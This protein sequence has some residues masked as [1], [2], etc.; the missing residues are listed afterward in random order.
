MNEEL[1]E[2]I[3]V[4]MVQ[5]DLMWEDPESNMRLL[6]DM[7]ARVAGDVD[8]II[9]PETFSTGFTMKA[10]HYAEQENGSAHLWMQQLTAKKQAVVTGSLITRTSEHIYNRLYWVTPGGVMSYYDKRHLFR[11]GLEDRFF[12]PGFERKILTW[13]PFVS[14]LRS[15]T[16]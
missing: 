7:L 1:T 12:Y 13:D 14:C 6:D 9:L 3:R 2:L 11:M 15:A 16:I 5:P 4:C 10:D 8:L